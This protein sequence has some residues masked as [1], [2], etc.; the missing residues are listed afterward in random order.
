MVWAGE[1]NREIVQQP[2]VN[3]FFAVIRF[4]FL[5]VPGQTNGKVLS[6]CFPGQAASFFFSQEDLSNFLLGNLEDFL[7]FCCEMAKKTESVIFFFQI[8]ACMP[9]TGWH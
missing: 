2:N 1:A 4:F 9:Y 7:F 6:D 3:L 8:E 5:N